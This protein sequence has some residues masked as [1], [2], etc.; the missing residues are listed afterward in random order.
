MKIEIIAF[1]TKMPAWVQQG[2]ST[3]QKR[4]PVNFT[5]EVI[6]LSLLKRGKNADIK[7]IQKK[8]AQLMLNALKKNAHIVALDIQG[9]HF[10]SEE[11]AKQLAA[12]ETQT[13]TLQL[14]IGGPE[15]L[16]SECLNASTE[17]WSLSALTLSH[18]IARL[19]LTEALYRCWTINQ[20]HPYHK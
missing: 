11:M 3:Y 14:L 13:S 18:P 10:S 8:E 17:R 4:L 6:E 20:N 19:V 5:I 16:S 15:G 1:G 2:I 7:A 12:I 9:K